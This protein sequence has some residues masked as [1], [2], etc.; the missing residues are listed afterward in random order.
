MNT[1]HVVGVLA[2]A[3]FMASTGRMAGPQRID[4]RVLAAE[5][6]V[7]VGR[8]GHP[9]GT[10]V[11]VEATLRCK[12]RIN[13]YVRDHTLVV[14]RVN[15]VDLPEPVAFTYRNDVGSDD[16]GVPEGC[17]T[18]TPDDEKLSEA[19]QFRKGKREEAPDTLHVLFVH[20]E[21]GWSGVP[22]NLPPGM[23]IVLPYEWNFSF[24]TTLVVHHED[25]VTRIPTRPPPDRPRV[26]STER[27]APATAEKYWAGT[28]AVLYDA[29]PWITT[30]PDDL[31]RVMRELLI[32]DA[33]RYDNDA[34][35]LARALAAWRSDPGERGGV[36]V[37]VG[38]MLMGV[39]EERAWV[40]VWKEFRVSD[41]PNGP[42]PEQG[43]PAFGAVRCATA[44]AEHVAVIDSDDARLV[45]QFE[46]G[47]ELRD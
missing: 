17:V 18:L 40:I 42:A 10:A 44:I 11:V 26:F 5:T 45:R 14:R 32:A 23:R 39:G 33:K 4:A 21:A 6:S 47:R 20:E 7:V 38:A 28:G 41:D 27:P 36:A 30:R 3:C 8:L 29:D 9:L 31:A 43:G 35:S 22:G 15:G 12:L 19:A 2:V 37:P 46:V 25:A 16:H 24:A 1:L 13:P 34:E